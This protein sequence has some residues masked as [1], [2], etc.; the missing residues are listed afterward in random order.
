MTNI[1]NEL[2]LKNKEV[3]DLMERKYQQSLEAEAKRQAQPL[4]VGEFEAK[5]K[6]MTDNREKANKYIDSVNVSL[7]EQVNNVKLTLTATRLWAIINTVAL[8]A[9]ISVIGWL[10]WVICR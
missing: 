10:L 7:R 9:N 1:D 3:A 4:T 5:W 2:E 6:E 8:T